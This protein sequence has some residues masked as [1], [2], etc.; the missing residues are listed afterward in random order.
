MYQRAVDFRRS[1][2]SLQT[3]NFYEI[4]S[5]FGAWAFQEYFLHLPGHTYTYKHNKLNC[6]VFSVKKIPCGVTNPLDT[7][8]KAHDLIKSFREM[9]VLKGISDGNECIPS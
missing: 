4:I 2:G 5:D 3:R 9:F 8:N 6:N 1:T 7:G